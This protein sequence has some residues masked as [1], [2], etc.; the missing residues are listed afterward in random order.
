MQTKELRLVQRPTAQKWGAGIHVQVQAAKSVRI[1]SVG[2]A[3]PPSPSPPC[4]SHVIIIKAPRRTV[5]NS[6][7]EL[8]FIQHFQTLA[9][10][11]LPLE[12]HFNIF[13]N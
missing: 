6:Y 11:I 8:C 7:V 12:N 1:E 5:I 10:E 4:D 3:V 13:Q 9:M 2:R